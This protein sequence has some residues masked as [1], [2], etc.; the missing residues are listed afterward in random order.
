MLMPETI[1]SIS[2]RLNGGHIRLLSAPSLPNQG[3]QV[4]LTGGVKAVFEYLCQNLHVVDRRD[5]GRQLEYKVASQISG[6]FSLL[7]LNHMV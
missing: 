2:E 6:I 5:W 1:L 7:Q 3:T 4:N